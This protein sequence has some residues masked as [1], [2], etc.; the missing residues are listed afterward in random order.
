MRPIKRSEVREGTLLLGERG[1]PVRVLK[2]VHGQGPLYLVKPF[3]GEGFVAHEQEALT[4]R[5]S[6]GEVLYDNPRGRQALHHFHSPYWD[7]AKVDEK[8]FGDNEEEATRLHAEW[9]QGRDRRSLVELPLATLLTLSSFHQAEFN[10]ARSV[11]LQFPSNPASIVD[12][13]LLGTWLG[14]GCHTSPVLCIGGAVK[15]DD[16]L[17]AVKAYMAR[18]RPHWSLTQHGIKYYVK[19]GFIRE[20]LRRVIVSG[21][22]VAS[23]TLMGGMSMK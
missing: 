15:V 4:V 16:L 19:G 21:S 1:Q 2:V 6:A 7:G 17:D 13:H 14:D 22:L 12:P 23:L 20:L 11:K 10:P 5:Y 18:E 9:R 3:K 8:Y